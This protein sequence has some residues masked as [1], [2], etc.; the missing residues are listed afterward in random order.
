MS[1]QRARLALIVLFLA[2]S[3]FPRNSAAP[4]LLPGFEN[5]AAELRWEKV[6]LAVPDP[7][8]A[9]EDMQFLAA[10]PHPA[11]SPRDHKTAEYVARKFREAGL[12]TSIVE[13]RVWM[14]YPAEVS[15][16]VVAPAKVRMHGPTPEPVDGENVHDRAQISAGFNGYSPSGDVEADV[17]YANYG[18]PEDFDK[19]HELGVDV[20]GKIVMIRYGEIFRGAKVFVAQERGAAA[21][22]LY[23]DPMDDGFFKGDAYPNGPWRPPESVQRGTVEFGFEHPGDPTTPGFASLPSLPASKRVQPEANPD[24]PGIPVTPLSAHD[25]QPILENLAG[26]S[27]PQGWQGALPFTYHVGPGPV[28]VKLHLKQDYAYRTIWNVIGKIPGTQYPNEWVIAGNHRDAWV[29]G[30]VDPVSGTAAMLEAVRGIGELLKEGWRP[31]R[32][33]VFASWDAEEQGLIGSTEWAEEHEA[34]LQN[35]VAYFNTDLGAYGP[36]FRAS[37]TPSL[38]R[39]VRDVTRSV[40]SPKGGTLYESWSGSTH[41]NSPASG[42]GY[43]VALGDLGSGSDYTVF[44]DHLGIPSTDVRST[45]DYG[46]YHSAY[47]NYEWFRRFGDT[48]F[49]Y[50]QELSR[51]FGLEVVRMASV[52]IL[53]YDYES[54][55]N[56]ISAYLKTAEKSS[57]DVFGEQSPAFHEVEASAERFTAAAR[58][59]AET[60]RSS[61]HTAQRNRILIQIERSLLLSNGLPRRPWFRH[62]IFA[63]SELKVYSAAV[64]PGVTEA[65]DRHDVELTRAQLAELAHALNRA[66]HLME[67]YSPQ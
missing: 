38:K 49:V 60:P 65:I 45:G 44:I 62:A 46:V 24:I 54:Y 55:G 23:S 15:V 29:Y 5:P 63:P 16:D 58:N 59:F 17:V 34:D 42:G 11:G 6:F 22:I 10:E 13:Y 2:S 67:S 9:E 12:E 43:D 18:R 26:Q 1:S 32:T 21:V 53:P 57:R 30:A 37:A 33:V 56:E 61:G 7:H 41:M 14:N 50:S 19:L 8:R 39:F 25:A 36:N 51:V 40:P 64:L 66:A 20:R 52:D 48:T 27:S 4:L 47:D 28:R 3:A 35:A 31:K